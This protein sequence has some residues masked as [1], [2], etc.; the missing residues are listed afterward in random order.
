MSIAGV[1]KMKP[2]LHPDFQPYADDGGTVSGITGKGFAVLAAD[3]RLISG[4]SIQT[5]NQPK[6]F[7]LTDKTVIG[8]AGCWCDCLTFVKIL[9]NRL[10]HYRYENNKPMSTVAVA[11]LV[12]NMLYSRRFFP[13]YV[14]N[15]VAGIDKDG[16]GFIYSYDPVGSY[17]PLKCSCAGAATEMI[18]PFLDCMV[19]G[20]NQTAKADELKSMTKEK[21]KELLKRAYTAA[22]ERH[23][24]TG[25]SLQI[26]T[27]TPDGIEEE[28]FQLR[29]D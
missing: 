18:L 5:R 15:T 3:T 1:D 19:D 13:Y 8:S 11:Q 28:M 20:C 6:V 7:K 24:N 17:E 10:K 22:A 12:S 23:M 16:Q 4:Y 26:V 21:A 27:V 25:D 9:T 2:K 14:Y 29:K